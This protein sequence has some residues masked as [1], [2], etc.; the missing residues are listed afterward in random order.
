M[1]KFLKATSIVYLS[2]LM[3]V[4]VTLLF[5][6]LVKDTI[7]SLFAAKSENVKRAKQTFAA[8]KNITYI[9]TKRTRVSA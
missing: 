4:V 8:K 2:L 3:V 6:S 1:K 5:M 9:I 7:A